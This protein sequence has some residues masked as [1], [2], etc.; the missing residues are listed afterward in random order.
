[1]NQDNEEAMNTSQQ[2]EAIETVENDALSGMPSPEEIPDES[3]KTEEDSI[4]EDLSSTD[5]YWGSKYSLYDYFKNHTTIL[6]AVISGFV[7]FCTFCAYVSDYTI[8]TNFLQQFNLSKTLYQPNEKSI[9][10]SFALS[11]VPLIIYSVLFFL[12]FYVFTTHFS[13]MQLARYTSIQIADLKRRYKGNSKASKTLKRL[14]REGENG[15]K[16]YHH[17]GILAPKEYV[18]AVHKASNT[19][20]ELAENESQIKELEKDRN[21]NYWRFRWFFIKTSGFKELILPTLLC[22]LYIFLDNNVSALKNYINLYVFSTVIVLAFIILAIIGA[23]FVSNAKMSRKDVLS[24]EKGELYEELHNQDMRVSI[25]RQLLR[26]GIKQ[27][28][29]NAVIV[30]V[31]FE[32]LFATFTMAFLPNGIMAFANAHSSSINPS[33]S[34]YRVN[35]VS[36]EDSIYAIVHQNGTQFYLEEATIT[37]DNTLIINKNKILFLNASELQ[38]ET[39]SFSGV[40]IQEEAPMPDINSLD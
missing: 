30:L 9:L 7:A 33:S 23:S 29:P 32:V 20:I 22:W 18:D 17:K 2:E 4:E 26:K 38:A 3:D 5:D 10:I 25:F 28:F 34:S 1:M 11:C 37:E 19:L 35:V 16:G 8:K 39:M 27:F 24:D 40:I 36:F 6:I 15:I 13:N 14:V 21:K 12:Y 31:V